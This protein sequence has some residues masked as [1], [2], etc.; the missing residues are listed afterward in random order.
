MQHGQIAGQESRGE[1]R[2]DRLELAR[3]NRCGHFDV[4]EFLVGVET[5]QRFV[6][7]LVKEF[8]GPR[9]WRSCVDDA[10]FHT[11]GER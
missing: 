8:V 11:H 10:S 3:R 2:V 7:G 6:V 1:L 4:D 9:G 5:G